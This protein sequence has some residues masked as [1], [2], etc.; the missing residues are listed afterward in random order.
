[1]NK[2]AGIFGLGAALAAGALVLTMSSPLIAPDVATLRPARLPGDA[3]GLAEKC[4]GGAVRLDD[5]DAWICLTDQPTVEGEL[6]NL[7]AG[8]KR[9]MLICDLEDPVD[10]G[11]WRTEVRYL[12]SGTMPP[13][14]KLVCADLLW[15]GVSMSTVET[16]TEACL[17]TACAPCPVTAG[18]WGQCPHCL[19]DSTPSCAEACPAPVEEIP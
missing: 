14:C 9:D 15:P 11:N 19:S 5:G 6:T 7:P 12:P 18:D 8:Q 17:R 10:S 16:G 13:R 1:M 3:V 4:P 2:A